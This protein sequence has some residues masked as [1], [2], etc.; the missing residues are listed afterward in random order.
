MTV[1]DLSLM[2]VVFIANI[3]H[4]TSHNNPSTLIDSNRCCYFVTI[5]DV[6]IANFSIVRMNDNQIMYRQF[7][8]R[9]GFRLLYGVG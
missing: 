3:L 9:R 6:V 7:L 2:S 8:C 5:G 4:T 1:T